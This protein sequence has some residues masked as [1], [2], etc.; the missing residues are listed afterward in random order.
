MS[1]KVKQKHGGAINRF[2]KGESGNPKGQK[3]KLLAHINAELKQEGY[4][5]I[6]DLD[7]IEGFQILLQLPEEKI[8]EIKADPEKPLFLRKIAGFMN[9]PRAMEMLDRMLDR[10]Y[11]KATQK[12]ELTGKD[13][14]PLLSHIT[15][16][17]DNGCDPVNPGAEGNAG[18]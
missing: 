14:I 8:K 3:P 16:N 13:G 5:P 6:K 18:I 1:I 10:A 9:S 12:A 4:D 11:G 17:I 7:L 2:V 15:L